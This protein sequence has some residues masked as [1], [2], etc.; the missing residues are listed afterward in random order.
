[1]ILIDD[2]HEHRS[3][4]RRRLLRDPRAG[5]S[6]PRVVPRDCPAMAERMTDA[7]GSETNQ[8]VDLGTC[9][10]HAA[11]GWF[12]VGDAAAFIDPWSTGS[13][14]A[15]TAG[16]RGPADFEVARAS[17]APSMRPCRLRRRFLGLIRNFYDHSFRELIV[18]GEG[19]MQVH[20]A[21]VNMLAGEVFGRIPFSV[22]WRWDLMTAFR[23]INRFHPLNERIRP[24]SLLQSGGIG[25]PDP[26]A[27]VCRGVPRRRVGQPSWQSA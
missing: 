26:V 10:R 9:D 15:S 25:L 13:V 5:E 21:V 14:S 4:H 6:P 17:V 23:E 16:A 8:V 1:M 7:T 27:G 3:G 22:R 11:D 19:P 20:R 2:D 24:H 12:K 18:A